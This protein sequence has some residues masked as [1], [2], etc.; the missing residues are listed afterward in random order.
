MWQ[1]G[2][3]STCNGCKK[4]FDNSPRYLCLHCR[5]GKKHDD[6][7][8]DYCYYCVQDMMK[9]TPKGIEMEKKSEDRLYSDETRLLYNANETYRH[10]SDT[11]VYLMI[12]LQYN[13]NEQP[14]YEF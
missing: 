3:A 14:Y 13:C 4:G 6:G 5:Q 11:H 1:W 9:K 12:A 10:N 8:F 2:R 7:Y